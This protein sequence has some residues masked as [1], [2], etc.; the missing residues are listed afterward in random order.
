M[1]WNWL[2]ILV[3]SLD[4]NKTSTAP[5]QDHHSLSP[6]P[7]VTVL[8]YEVDCRINFTTHGCPGHEMSVYALGS[9]TEKNVVSVYPWETWETWNVRKW[10]IRTS[11]FMLCSRL[12]FMTLTS[13]SI[14]WLNTDLGESWIK[15]L[16]NLPH[17]H[18]STG[19]AAVAQTWLEAWVYFGNRETNQSLPSVVRWKL[20]QHEP[21]SGSSSE[22]PCKPR[23]RG[24]KVCIIHQAIFPP[25]L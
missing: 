7:S 1:L 19:A 10:C 18:T 4:H 20:F 3:S 16:K 13:R 6:H 5:S 11:T 12:F 22:K 23:T 9:N 15:Y 14:F 8:M 25:F 17:H 21:L 24:M 2:S